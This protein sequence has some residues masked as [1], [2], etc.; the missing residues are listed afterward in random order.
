[1]ACAAKSIGTT[2]RAQTSMASY[3]AKFVLQPRAI[4]CDDSRPP[5]IHNLK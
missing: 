3:R 4:R 2:A 1:L 5:P